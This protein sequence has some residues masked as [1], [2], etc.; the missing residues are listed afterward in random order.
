V[1]AIQPKLELNT[2]PLIKTLELTEDT[3]PKLMRA[4][5]APRAVPEGWSSPRI[6]ES[7]KRV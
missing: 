6:V 4:L 7:G 5:A 1:G 3:K 2:K